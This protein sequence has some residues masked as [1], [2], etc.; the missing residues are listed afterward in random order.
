MTVTLISS[1]TL[2]VEMLFNKCK[3]LTKTVFWKHTGQK[4][5]RNEKTLAKGKMK[6]F[7]QLK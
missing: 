5:E 6:Y 7:F 2:M 4:K 3:I 1:V